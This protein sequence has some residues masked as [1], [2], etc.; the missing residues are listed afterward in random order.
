MKLSI[1]YLK[2][3]S[4]PSPYLATTHKNHLFEAILMSGHKIRHGKDIM[5]IVS[6]RFQDTLLIYGSCT[7]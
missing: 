1:S 4:S 2:R 5:K 3:L 6:I 7:V